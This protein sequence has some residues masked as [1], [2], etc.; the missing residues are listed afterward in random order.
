MT[1]AKHTIVAFSF[2]FP[3]LA[4]A[5]SPIG[6]VGGS[7]VKEG[8][9]SVEQRVGFTTDTPSE[10]SHKR[11]QSRQHFDYGF[12]DW[13]ALRIITAQDKRKGDNLE[14]A[15]ITLE[16]RFQIIEE[17]DHGWSGGLRLQ[18]THRDGDKTPHE[19]DARIMAEVPFNDVWEWR[20]NTVLEHDIGENA[21]DGIQLEFR[22]QL[23][24]SMDVSD[25]PYL[26]SLRLGVEMFNDFGR[27][28][29]SSGFNEED[30]QL[31]PVARM[32]FVNGFYAQTGY[33][34]SI[35]EAGA[36]NVFKLFVGKKL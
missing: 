27:L 8:A 35:S 32:G 19:I 24:R 36:D 9:V 7:K 23:S 11:V 31:G 28:N 33:R 30:H 13:Y 5:A 22:N 10:S 12:N 20:H 18:Y 14:Y 34:T 16:N 1:F 29:Q 26:T 6:N 17:R 2:F 21:V 25:T 4:F 15:G 3:A